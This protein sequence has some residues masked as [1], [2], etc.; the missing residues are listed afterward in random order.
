MSLT[1]FCPPLERVPNSATDSAS[2][3]IGTGIW[4]EAG[5]GFFCGWIIVWDG[6]AAVAEGKSLMSNE[7]IFDG[8]GRKRILHSREPVTALKAPMS[9][10]FLQFG[11]TGFFLHRDR[12]PAALEAT[13]VVGNEY[14]GEEKA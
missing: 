13:H 9:S 8:M 14:P 12:V 5:V 11:W 7:Y 6:Y 4:V 3:T 1:R 2:W 10:F